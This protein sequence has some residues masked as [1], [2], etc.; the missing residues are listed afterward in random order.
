MPASAMPAWGAQVPPYCL[1]PA[2]WL[3]LFR[4]VPTRSGRRQGHGGSGPENTL[5]PAQMLFFGGF[6]FTTIILPKISLLPAFVAGFIRVFSLNKPGIEKVPVLPVTS[7]VAIV[8]R[9]PH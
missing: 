9:L 3:R 6:A 2:P 5:R 4:R 8:V 1:S 7:L